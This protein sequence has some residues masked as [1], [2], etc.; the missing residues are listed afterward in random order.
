MIG[1][2]YR[3]YVIFV[4]CRLNLQGSLEATALVVLLTPIRRPWVADSPYHTSGATR[5][6]IQVL[7]DLHIAGF[8]DTCMDNMK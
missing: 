7:H 4:I 8:F 3:T 5:R 6:E 1:V 2:Y